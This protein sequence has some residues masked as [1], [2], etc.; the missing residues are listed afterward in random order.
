MFPKADG[1][2]R[3]GRSGPRHATVHPGDGSQSA[4]ELCPVITARCEGFQGVASP[5]RHRLV[6]LKQGLMSE[7]RMLNNSVDGV[8]AETRGELSDE[9]V[10]EAMRAESLAC[11]FI[12]ISS[13]KQPRQFKLTV[14]KL[15]VSIEKDF[16][17]CSKQIDLCAT[18]ALYTVCAKRAASVIFLGVTQRERGNFLSPNWPQQSRK[19]P[20]CVGVSVS[21]KIHTCK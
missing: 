12:R 17:L 13:C 5:P 6:I 16:C 10:C 20:Q 14:I 21:L 18:Y 11:F 15:W 7:Q 19:V 1:A 9:S 3:A 2:G 4:V 8:M